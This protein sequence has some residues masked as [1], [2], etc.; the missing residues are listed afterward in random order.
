M[1]CGEEAGSSLG[2]EKRRENAASLAPQSPCK[3]IS[4][5]SSG[6]LVMLLSRRD[7]RISLPGSMMKQHEL[8]RNNLSFLPGADYFWAEEV[9]RN[10]PPGGEG[11][12]R[13]PAGFERVQVADRAG[14]RAPGSGEY[15]EDGAR[16]QPNA[17]RYREPEFAHR[18][19]GGDCQDGASGDAGGVF[20]NV[21]AAS[22]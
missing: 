5:R 17:R 3:I 20:G 6:A 16:S 13:I 1:G 18:K 14:D 12:Q 4:G 8:L 2:G 22:E 7:C 21:G 9:A 11:A 15:A 10:C 19:R